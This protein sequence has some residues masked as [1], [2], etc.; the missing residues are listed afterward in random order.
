M[1]LD[2]LLKSIRE[3]GEP[4]KG[5]AIVPAKFFGEDR[6][7]KIYQEL[8]TEGKIEG[9]NLSPEERKQGVKAYRKSKID[10]EKF[11]NQVLKT[12]REVGSGDGGIPTTPPGRRVA[13]S[14]QRLL[15]GARQNVDIK[16]PQAEPE[17]EAEIEDDLQDIDKKLDDLLNEIRSGNKEEKKSAEKQRKESEREKRSKR[18]DKRESA[19]NFLVK[20]IEKVLAPIENFFN[21]IIDG[22]VKVLLAKALFKF[23]DW[24]ADPE[25]QEK[26]N[27]IGRFF[28][29]FWPGIIGGLLLVGTGL[30]SFAL[31]LI[32]NGAKLLASL[33]KMTLR[34]AGIGAGL[35]LKGGKGL[36]KLAAANPLAT[37]LV[38]AGGT[39]AVATGVGFMKS[40]E[41]EKKQVNREAKA[42]GVKPEV[43]KKEIQE[44]KKSPMSMI[45][46]GMGNIGLFSGGGKARGTDIVPAMLTPG[47]FIMSKGAVDT[48]GTDF[49]ESINAAGGG[50]NKPKFANGT[51]YAQGGGAINPV[52]TSE[53]F[54][55]RHIPGVSS[56]MHMGADIGVPVGTPLKAYTG[57]Q[58][59][60]TSPPSGAAGYGPKWLIWKGDDGKGHMFAHMSQ[61][62]V[63]P[64]ETLRK[65][66]NVGKSGNAGTGPHLHWEVS[67]NPSD[68]GAD[69]SA[70]R[71]RLNPLALFGKDAP[72]GG[73]IKPGEGSTDVAPSSESGA[74][75]GSLMPG[76][77]SAAD[78]PLSAILAAAYE[79]ARLEQ[80]AYNM[81][82][83]PPS[84][85]A[86][87]AAGVAMIPMVTSGVHRQGA[88]N[89]TPQLG[90]VDPLNST[91]FV[92]RSMYNLGG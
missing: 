92:M 19:K 77:S 43:V 24:F 16:P 82:L 68:V 52:V 36:F 48:F 56:G 62:F 66:Q 85:A 29:D 37:G 27:A 11:V 63:R 8:L 81:G 35:A 7:D 33:V 90:S 18:E 2:D 67:T 39:A 59:V 3:E 72:F 58:V 32:T 79:R 64:G 61:V 13:T 91:L 83:V 23:I 4:S 74:E 46:E 89:D 87:P 40:Q 78:L 42:R 28:K 71:S 1:D 9:D 69:K 86:I 60:E 50:T 14:N 53:P 84:A 76:S 5:G 10:F 34:L 70:R 73:D 49:M 30:G 31:T 21:K 44:A 26:I 55:N 65:G 57:G 25:N 47:E 17:P 80:E 45:G 75:P 88:S 22:L 12:K 20:P 54:I 38:V 6:Y 15:P 51:A 41:E